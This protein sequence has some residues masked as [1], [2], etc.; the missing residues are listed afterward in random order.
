[1]KVIDIKIDFNVTKNIKRFVYV[2]AIILDNNIYLIDSGIYGSEKIIEDTLIKNGYNPE[3]IKGIFLTHSH[4]DHIGGASYF[5]EKYNAVIYASEGEKPWIEDIDLQYNKRPIPNFYSLVKKSV[6]VDYIVKNNESISLDKNTFINVVKTPGHSLDE[7]S[8]KIDNVLFIGD[9][10][11]LKN[12]LLIMVDKASLINS[13]NV[14]STIKGC[15]I[16]YPAWDSAYTLDTMKE[17]IKEAKDMILKLEAVVLKLD[18]G[19]NL[20]ELVVKVCD[21]L[22]INSLNKNPL[23]ST[24]IAS[25]RRR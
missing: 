7:V 24:T 13:L 18:N 5:K 19:I 14:L 9:T 20:D 10:V 6:K 2:Y 4:P 3:N 16:F 22:G 11:P 17:I 23:F 8:Y 21:D 15:D 25:L 12:D 1:M